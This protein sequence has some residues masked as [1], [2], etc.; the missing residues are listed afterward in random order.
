MTIKRFLVF[1]PPTA[2]TRL[3]RSM[4]SALFF[5]PKCEAEC[6]V[7]QLVGRGCCW[8]QSNA[9]PPAVLRP[10]QHLGCCRTRVARLPHHQHIRGG[11][12]TI[13]G[14]LDPLPFA[15][16]DRAAAIAALTNWWGQGDW[17]ALGNRSFLL[18]N[19]TGNVEEIMWF[20]SGYLTFLSHPNQHPFIKVYRT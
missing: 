5:I 13:P 8:A 11:T 17:N 3:S 9:L 10:G 16:W 14:V 12:K 19:V 6:A 18:G 2:I 7:S 4:S 15:F 20:R 1:Q